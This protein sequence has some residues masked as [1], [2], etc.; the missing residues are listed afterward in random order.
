MSDG[1]T[2]NIDQLLTQAG[3]VD[4]FATKADTAADAGAHVTSLDDAYGLF[5][6][7]FAQLLKDPQQR[8]VETLT[9]TAA[10]LHQMV[11]NLQGCAKTYQEAEE[12]IV[13]LLQTL[14]KLLDAST[15]IPSA[16]GGN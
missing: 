6:Q 5:C 12:K 1:F 9:E 14:T 4:G 2:V 7:P 15:P 8:G 3:A 16:R 11:T 13:I 10:V